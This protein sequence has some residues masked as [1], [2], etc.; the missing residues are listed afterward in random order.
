MTISERKKEKKGFAFIVQENFMKR[1]RNITKKRQVQNKREFMTGGPLASQI[2]CPVCIYIA[3]YHLA[4]GQC[5][6]ALSEDRTQRAAE[7][8]TIIIGKF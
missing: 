7:L 2:I 3:L 5:S 4:E 1:K 6:G 8:L